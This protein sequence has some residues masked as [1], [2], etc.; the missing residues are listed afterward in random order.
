MLGIH[1]L[2]DAA[3]LRQSVRAACAEVRQAEQSSD[4]RV[5]GTCPNSS[6][7]TNTIAD[8]N[9]TLA[10]STDDAG[11]S[12]A[13]ACIDLTSNVKDV[14]PSSSADHLLAVLSSS[15]HY[16]DTQPSI[17]DR[18]PRY[19]FIDTLRSLDAQQQNT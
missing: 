3:A 8:L 18:L 6:D 7:V 11:T 14:H 4:V 13:E 2:Q 17:S 16:T 5:V 1:K 19:F 10:S 9:T 12:T 15:H